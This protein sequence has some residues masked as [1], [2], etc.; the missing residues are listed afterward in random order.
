M[1]SSLTFCSIFLLSLQ[2]LAMAFTVN[3]DGTVTD[4]TTGLVWQQIV[5]TTP[6]TWE[7]ALIYCEDLSLAGNNDWRLPNIKELKSI[8]DDSAHFPAIDTTIFPGTLNTFYWSSTSIVG[9]PDSAWQVD[10]NDGR[11]TSSG[12]VVHD[13]GKASSFYT[14]CVR[15][16]Q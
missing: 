7:T 1:K 15:G 12:G 6:R 8:T 3:T 11:V 2:S 5:D 10:F 16:G 14:R 4:P 13:T 9:T